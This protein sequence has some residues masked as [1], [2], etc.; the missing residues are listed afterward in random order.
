MKLVSLLMVFAL[1]AISCNSKSE[2][3]RE[4]QAWFDE[5]LTQ[6]Q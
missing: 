2:A 4:A 1:L 3:H 5:S 6:L